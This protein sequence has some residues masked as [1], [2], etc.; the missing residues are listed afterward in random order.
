MVAF[1][2]FQGYIVS[3]FRFMGGHGEQLTLDFGCTILVSQLFFWDHWSCSNSNSNFKLK[4]SISG[5]RSF[6]LDGC[7]STEHA[8][9]SYSHTTF[10]MPLKHWVMFD[11]KNYAQ[12]LHP[13]V[14][15]LLRLKP[16]NVWL[17]TRT[18]PIGRIHDE[19]CYERLL[20]FMP[21]LGY[22]VIQMR[23]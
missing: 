6:H 15:S 18:M 14:V 22:C 4:T 7:V 12:I 13:C 23:R 21:K 3:V 9:P 17:E 10:Q 5:S 11:S 20:K 19:F 16:K 1:N 2:S 8:H